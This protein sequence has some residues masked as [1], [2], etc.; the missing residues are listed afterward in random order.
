M[1]GFNYKERLVRLV[2]FSLECQ[3]LR[4]GLIYKILRGIDRLNRQI[5]LHRLKQSKSSFKQLGRH[6]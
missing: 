4:D 1:D 6:L 3:R 5:L 2:H